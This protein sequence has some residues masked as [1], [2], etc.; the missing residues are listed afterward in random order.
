VKDAIRHHSSFNL[1]SNETFL[2]VDVFIPKERAFDQDA[3]RHVRQQSLERGGRSFYLASPENT[4]IH[5]LEWYEM[6]GRLSNRQWA[7]ILGILRSQ[8]A[9]LDIAYLEQWA[10]VLQVRDLLDQA[11]QEAGLR[12]H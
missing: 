4:I 7:D 9:S 1:I 11:L 10:S 6:G 2:K 5:K 3:F 8:T 12:Q